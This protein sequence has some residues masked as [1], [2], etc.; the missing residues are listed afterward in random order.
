MEAIAFANVITE[1]GTTRCVSA[2][3]TVQQGEPGLCVTGVT[4]RAAREIDGLVLAAMRKRGLGLPGRAVTVDLAFD[5]PFEA[6]SELAFATFM[7]LTETICL[8]GN[9]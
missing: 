7:A 5:V 2:T 9:T 6:T 8:S 3:A 4:D 1:C